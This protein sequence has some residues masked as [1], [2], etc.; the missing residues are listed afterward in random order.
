MGVHVAPLPEPSFHLYPYPIPLGCP[1]APA[2]SDLLHA[3]S[4]HWS[5]VFHMVIYMF[6][7]YF[8]KS[9]HPHLLPQ[10]PKIC[11]LHL[12]LFYDIVYR[13]VITI[14][15]N[16]IHVNIQ[17]LCFSFWLTSLCIIGSS[18]IH[19]ISTV[20]NAVLFYSWVIFHCVYVPQFPY[21]FACWW[22][23]RLLPCPSYCKQCCNE[24]WGTCISFSLVSSGC[25]PSNGISGL[26]G[27]SIPSFLRNLHTVLHSSCTSLHSHQQGKR[28]PFSPHLLPYLLFV[29]FVFMALWP[30]W[31]ETSLWVLIGMGF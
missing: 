20:S 2:L 4:L 21:P 26:Y 23:F 10:S 31:D 3:S 30:A 12:C 13:I 29:D 11:S 18:F 9:S 6:Q 17:Y 25:M 19:L 1:R 16:S 14:F 8:L 5:S 15:L 28:V 22:T 27:S 7:C 24:H